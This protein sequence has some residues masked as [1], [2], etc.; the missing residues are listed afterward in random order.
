MSGQVCFIIAPIGSPESETRRRSDQIL[1]HLIR[2]TVEALGYTAV[3]ADEISEPGIITSQV[4]QHVID[5]PLVVADLSEWNPNV[6]YELAIRHAIRK[7]LVQL[8][9]KDEKIPFDIASM[10]TISFDHRDLDSVEEAKAEMKRQCESA[11]KPNAT[12]DSPIS[13]TIDLQAL[14]QSADPED[15]T[16]ADLVATVNDLRS[17]M[18]LMTH[19]A[20]PSPQL[21][22][23]PD[24]LNV[25]SSVARTRVTPKSRDQILRYIV[26]LCRDSDSH[27]LYEPHG[28]QT[29][30]SG[31]V[32][33]ASTVIET[34]KKR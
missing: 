22:L 17:M 30:E 26:E 25:I 12:I 10:R 3:R 8:I 14:R 29:P 7:P 18:S 15:R 13:A 33:D 31:D 20:K 9:R 28:S 16:L 11:L 23:Y 2:P 19:G 27:I 34:K 21:F 5:D 1:R 4:I 24:D 32:A 6:F